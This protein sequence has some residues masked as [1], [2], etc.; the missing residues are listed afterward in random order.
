MRQPEREFPHFGRDALD[1]NH[2]LYSIIEHLSALGL[3]DWVPHLCAWLAQYD[4]L[5]L[6]AEEEEDP[7][8]CVRQILLDLRQ[9]MGSRDEAPPA[10]HLKAQIVD[11]ILRLDFVRYRAHWGVDLV[12]DQN[13]RIWQPLRQ[14][15]FSFLQEGHL[16]H[17]Q[18][19]LHIWIAD[20]H[21]RPS[22][23]QLRAYL[24]QPTL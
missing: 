17:P 11:N 5:E 8:L 14:S 9:R 3:T 21:P 18:E 12:A 20:R 10:E 22:F 6:Y 24:L 1:R 13:S 16:D 15:W 19:S 2:A 7:H 23:A 4:G